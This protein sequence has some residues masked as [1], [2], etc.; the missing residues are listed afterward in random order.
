MDVHP[1]LQCEEVVERDRPPVQLQRD[2]PRHVDVGELEDRG[3][4]KAPAGRRRELRA[5]GAAVPAERVQR[6]GVLEGGRELV[7]RPGDRDFDLPEHGEIPPPA[8]I[9]AALLPGHLRAVDVVPVALDVEHGRFG[10]LDETKLR[11]A[12]RV[13]QPAPARQ[14]E[15]I[16]EV[17]IRARD[18]SGQRRPGREALARRDQEVGERRL[19]SA[20][21]GKDTQPE[22]RSDA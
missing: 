6:E 19:R 10:P 7:P 5:V 4:V 11:V 16:G 20:E 13:R 18:A 3:A 1:A 17:V 21:E 8:P 15:Q 12:E 22:P 14:A 2:D 9:L